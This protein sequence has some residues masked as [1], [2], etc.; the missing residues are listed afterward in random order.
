MKLNSIYVIFSTGEKIV[1]RVSSLKKI[2]II[3]VLLMMELA[4]STPTIRNFVIGLLL[5]FQNE[6]ISNVNEL[7]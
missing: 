7:P 6:K 2:K 3:I 5:L 1:I 4:L